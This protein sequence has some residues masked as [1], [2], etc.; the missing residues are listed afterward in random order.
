VH[1]TGRTASLLR[2]PAAAFGPVADVLRGVDLAMVN[3]E[4]AVTRRG[5]PEPKTYHFRAPPSAYDAVRAAGI[6]AVSLANNHSLD[7]GRIGLLD[8]LDAARAAGFPVFGA[9][10]TAAEAYAPW[11]TEVRGARVAVLGFSQVRELAASWAARDDRPGIAMAHDTARALAAVRSTRER[12]DV[13]IVFNHWG[14][15]GVAC[16]NAEQKA[17][18]RALAGAGADVIVGAH[19]HTLQGDG[20][21]GSTYVAYG[22]GN[23]LWY[24]TSRST[25]TGVLRL[26][27]RGRVVIKNEFLPAIVGANGQPRLLAGAA[28]SRVS[29]RYAAL[30]SCTG[31]SGQPG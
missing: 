31:L 30:R 15:E 3:L 9:G 8:T 29:R 14:T 7:Y 19:A 27:V 22:M 25:E 12:A 24:A 20:W 5:T 21:L 18:A 23:F 17:F 26:T 13:V 28:G 6:D 2:D 4:S 1:F 10:R 16:P 11:V